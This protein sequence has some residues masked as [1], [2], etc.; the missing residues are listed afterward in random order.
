LCISTTGNAFFGDNNTTKIVGKAEV[1]F[2]F[3]DG[4]VKTL[5]DVLH[6]PRCAINL[7]FVYDFN[8]SR[9]HV[10]FDKGGCKLMK[11]NMVV[12]KGS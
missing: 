5:N 11:G 1:K 12:A 7:L 3:S 10:T 4:R 6:I 8:D 9:M 2:R